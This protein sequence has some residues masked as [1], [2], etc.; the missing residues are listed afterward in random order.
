MT[1]ERH[2]RDRSSVSDSIAAEVPLCDRIDLLVAEIDAVADHTR[3]VNERLA[4]GEM[5]TL[6]SG[7]PAVRP[8]LDRAVELLRECEGVMGHA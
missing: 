5:V 1:E 4:R 3:R 8:L 6:A 7:G 2:D